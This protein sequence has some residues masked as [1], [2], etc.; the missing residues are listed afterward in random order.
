LLLLLLIVLLLMMLS[1]L[2]LRPHYCSA[3]TAE[4]CTAAATDATTAKQQPVA[5]SPRTTKQTRRL[6]SGL[7]RLHSI[8]ISPNGH[9]V[10]TTTTAAAAAAAA[11]IMRKLARRAVATLAEREVLA[12]PLWLH[13]DARK[14]HPAVTSTTRTTPNRTEPTHGGR[15]GTAPAT[16]TAARE[17]VGTRAT[18]TRRAA[19]PRT[20]SQLP[21][22]CRE[23]PS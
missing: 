20:A 4:Q 22:S 15:R 8:A 23:A 19:T 12:R 14:N 16:S 17:D 9:V 6:L 1:M 11:P 18:H 2:L 3:V 10:T 7:C 13:G 5:T 21:H